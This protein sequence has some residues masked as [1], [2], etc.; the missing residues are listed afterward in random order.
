MQPLVVLA[1]RLEQV[2]VP[3]ML[4]LD[5]GPR[6]VEAVV[7]VRLGREVHDHVTVGHERVDDGRVGHRPD[8]E[9]DGG[10]AV[11]RAVTEDG[12]ERGPVG[13]IRHGVEH[14]DR[15][16]RPGL[17]GAEDE[18]GADEAGPTRDE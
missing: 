2:K 3:T 9:P 15:P 16:V 6:A 18:V 8:H 4:S 13:G 11:I 17:A 10:S 14:G 5:E 7:V 1:D 12:V